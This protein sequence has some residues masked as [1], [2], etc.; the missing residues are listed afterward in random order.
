MISSTTYFLVG[1]DKYFLECYVRR[2]QSPDW[3][4]AVR[5]NDN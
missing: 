5:N 2:P 4:Y 3:Q 1:L